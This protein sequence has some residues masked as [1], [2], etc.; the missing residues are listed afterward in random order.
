MTDN[1]DLLKENPFSYREGK[2]KVF[3]QFRNREIMILKGKAAGKLLNKL[4]G[5]DEFTVQ[6]TLAKV[7]GH[8]K[9]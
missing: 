1:R 7:T 9:H 8:F 6:L 3:I 4:Y 2:D 5:E